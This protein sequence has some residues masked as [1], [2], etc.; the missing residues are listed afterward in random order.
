MSHPGHCIDYKTVCQSETAEAEIARQLYQEGASPGLRSVSED[1]VV[2]TQFWA[3]NFNK[4]LE[5]DKGNDMI[6]STH[7][8]KFQEK[9]VGSE[10][11]SHVK[12]VSRTI[13]RFS[14]DPQMENEKIC[15]DKNKEPEKFTC[16]NYHVLSEDASGNFDLRYLLCNILR[17]IS[18]DNQKV[19]SFSGWQVL[20]REIANV[21]TK[22]IVM[23]YLPPINAPV[24]EFSTIFGFVTYMQKLCKEVNMPYVNITLDLGTAM[25]AYKVVCNVIIHLGDFHFMKEVFAVPGMLI[26]GSGFENIAFQSG[27]STTGSLN[28]VIAGTHYNRCWKIHQHFAEALERLLFKRFCNENGVTN[29]RG[30]LGENSVD[31]FAVGAIGSVI[32]NQN[33]QDLQEQYGQYKDKIRSGLLGKTSQF[34]LVNYLDVMEALHLIHRAVQENDYVWRLEGWIRMMPYF[35]ALNK[36]NY[37]RY[38]SY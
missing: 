14:T 31:E 32:E 25:P 1:D 3:A 37:S 23:T 36:T 11:R 22:K 9:A 8:V 18:S 13:T 17:H 24:N 20:V 2:L 6:N 5:C 15:I 26:E 12:T 10:Y 27:I 34:W 38:G 35:F 33:F 30:I 28:G 7:L 29:V 21:A 4:K 19:P 16:P